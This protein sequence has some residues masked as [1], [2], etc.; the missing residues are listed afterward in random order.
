M[1]VAAVNC[2]HL[3]GSLANSLSLS[4]A[5]TCGSFVVVNFRSGT[6]SGTPTEMTAS[7]GSSTHVFFSPRVQLNIH[8][9]QTSMWLLDVRSYLVRMRNA[10]VAIDRA[11]SIGRSAS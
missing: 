3:I 6:L 7:M 8:V 9:A 10:A 4:E 11:L 5:T 2:C 1:D